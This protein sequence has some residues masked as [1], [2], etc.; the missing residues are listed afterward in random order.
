VTS[1]IAGVAM[2]QNDDLVRGYTVAKA[3][4]NKGETIGF[5]S[6]D[7]IVVIPCIYLGG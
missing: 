2:R 4:V 3:R 7:E 1:S 6:A 5:A